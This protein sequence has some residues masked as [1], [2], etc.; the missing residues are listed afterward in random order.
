MER[1]L[2][3][4]AVN[5]INQEIWVW[6]WIHKIRKLG[7]IVFIILR[8]YSG[9]IQGVIEN[10]TDLSEELS[11]GTVVKLKGEVVKEERA[12]Q[13]IE[14]K[15]KEIKIQSRVVED[16]PLQINKKKIS[17]NLDTLLDYRSV[18]LR[19]P[20][21]SAIFK[22]QAQIAKLFRE[23]LITQ[24]FTE[25]F[26]PKIVCAGAEGGSNIFKV[27]Y[28]DKTA[29]LA[30][31]PQFYKQ[32]MVGVFERVFEVG[33]VFRAEQ[34][35][36]ARHL[37]EYVSLDYEMGF[38]ENHLDIMRLENNL[39]IYMLKE[40]KKT[41][42]E[43]FKFFEMEIPFV[44]EE[45][46][47]LKLR[48]AQSILEKNYH[49]TCLGEPDLDPED[50]RLICQYSKEK[51][52]SEF[53]FITHFPSDKR[54]FYTMDDSE[55][56]GYTKSFDLLFRGLEITTG[57]QRINRYEDYLTKMKKLRMNPDNFNFYLEAFKY[58]MPPHGGLAI[59]L[60]RITARMLGLANIREASLFPR[61]IN[62][63]IP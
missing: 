59:G 54:P 24:N 61:D 33:S 62:R 39:L 63:L 3:N 5:F 25:I 38:I 51:Y 50:E 56:P 17:A 20:Q 53:I 22:I 2:I 9:F 4:Q 41:S 14:L 10:Q 52:N 15:I 48:E 21:I 7:G 29:Y 37:N 36:T 32:I 13:G 55:D 40:L 49:K 27:E 23:Y 19:Y 16:Y 42:Q 45:I 1:A 35:N 11:I 44:P 28:F 26:T 18:S 12:V 57:G 34:H 6:G 43:E 31:S 58:G 47:H 46:P 30:Q 60:E 8:D